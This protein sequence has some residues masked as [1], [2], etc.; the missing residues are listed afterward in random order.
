MPFLLFCSTSLKA[1][2]KGN[3]KKRVEIVYNNIV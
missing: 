1:Q 3:Y 2:Q